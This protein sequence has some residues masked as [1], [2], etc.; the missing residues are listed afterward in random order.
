MQSQYSINER[1]IIIPMNSFNGKI[2]LWTQL[3]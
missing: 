2:Y 3:Q 1:R